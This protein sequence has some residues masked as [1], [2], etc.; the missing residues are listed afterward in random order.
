M[1]SGPRLRLGVEP[2]AHLHAD[3][4]L[5]EK[6]PVANQPAMVCGPSFDVVWHPFDFEML[7]VL[8]QA[9]GCG[10][11]PSYRIVQMIVGRELTG[12]KK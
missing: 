9:N 1:W 7:E 4:K 2:R 5:E 3:G 8:E 11:S 12:V 6:F 10:P